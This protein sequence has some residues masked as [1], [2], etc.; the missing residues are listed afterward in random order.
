MDGIITWAHTAPPDDFWLVAGILILL[1]L[2]GFAGAFYYFLRKRIIEDTPTS[3]IRSAAQGYV[4]LTGIG[5]FLDGPPIV[6]PLTGKHCTWYSWQIEERR[7]SGRRTRWVTVERGTSGELFQLEDETGACVIDPEGASVTATT[8]DIWYGSS[9]R[10]TTG[11][12][13]GG[14]LSAGRYR[15]TEHR[16]L[17]G[18]PLY[19]IGLFQTVGGAGSEFNVDIDMRELLREWKQDSER[20][21]RQFD[22]N[23]DGE[24]DVQEWEAVRKQAYREVMARHAE[25]KT[26]EPM[27]LMAA[28]QD[29][30]RP[31]I[32][33]SVP[34][35][36]LVRRF[37]YR[38]IGLI[39][40]FFAAG[41]AATWII[42]LRLGG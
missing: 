4:E 23:S 39:I 33:S 29:R 16:L 35:D 30:R 18:E 12:G 20:L 9:A 17:P 15:Y 6:S 31:Y 11:P 38:S 27:N 41:A 28:T 40:L 36:D 19:A 25:R 7:R 42:G 32:L 1:T 3:L 24:I 10:P 34:Q 2:G 5:R 22:R 37:H 8:R 14:W 21:L 26:A 13:G